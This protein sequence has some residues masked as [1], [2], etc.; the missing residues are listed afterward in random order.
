MVK[1][2][3]ANAG[4]TGVVGSITG[5]GRSPG[6]GNVN[7]LQYSCLG[8]PMDR[9][10][11]Q[12]TVNGIERAGY[13][14]VTKQQQ[15]GK[16]KFYFVADIAPC[17][18]I[19]LTNSSGSQP[20]FLIVLQK[21]DVKLGNILEFSQFTNDYPC[22]YYTFFGRINKNKMKYTLQFSNIAGMCED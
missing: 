8:N 16:K 7:P 9:G 3:P 13:N 5:S 22:Q 10:T 21:N 11:W 20:W 17:S 2:L 19:P 15:N 1:S 4:A 18:I 12:A 14:L 6:E